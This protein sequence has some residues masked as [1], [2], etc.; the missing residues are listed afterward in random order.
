M[1]DSG[2]PVEPPYLR[3]YGK[4]IRPRTFDSHV[5]VVR[6]SVRKIVKRMREQLNY[7]F[8]AFKKHF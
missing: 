2:A 4:P 6:P 5:M 7:S 8:V 1:F 3:K